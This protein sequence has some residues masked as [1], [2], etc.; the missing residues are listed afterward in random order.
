LIFA[1]NRIKFN[2]ILPKLTQICI[3]KFARGVAAASPAPTPL[4]H[5][6]TIIYRVAQK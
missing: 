4:V 1:Q 3:K 2:Q 5:I 6:Q